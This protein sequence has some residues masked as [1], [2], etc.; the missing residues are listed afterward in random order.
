M[1]KEFLK[2]KEKERNAI[3]YQ[4]RKDKMKERY[5]NDAEYKKRHLEHSKNQYKRNKNE[6][7]HK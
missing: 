5:L 6:N 4:R 7:T 1:L 3:K 2:L